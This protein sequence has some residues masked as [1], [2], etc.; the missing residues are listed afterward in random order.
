M[1]GSQK[2]GTSVEHLV[3]QNGIKDYD[4]SWTKLIY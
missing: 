4:S 2:L 3:T 1:G